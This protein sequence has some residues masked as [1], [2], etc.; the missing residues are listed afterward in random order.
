MRKERRLRKSSDF[1]M[2]RRVGRS[3]ADGVLVLAA[4]RNGLPN[5][6]FG[7]VVGRRVGNA[8]TRNRIKRRL[9][10]AAVEANVAGGWDL[11]LIARNRAAGSDYHALKDSLSQLLRRSSITDRRYEETE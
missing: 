6:R 10:A 4:R 3:W 2:V 11:V 9:R 5:T 1:A 7:F 8:V